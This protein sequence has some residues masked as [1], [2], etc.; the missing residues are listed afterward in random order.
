[1]TI[2][3]PISGMIL[4]YIL[5]FIVFFLSQVNRLQIDKDLIVSTLRMTVQLILVGL[6]L[7]YVFEWES[8]IIVTGIFLLMI[9]FGAW[10][11]ME[12][13]GVAFFQ[14]FISLLGSLFLGTGFVLLFFILFIVGVTPWYDPQFFIP[15]AGMIIGNSMNGSTLAVERFFN[16]VKEKRLEIETKAALGANAKEASLEIF[17]QAYKAS[18]LPTLSSMTGMGIVFLPGM[19]TGQI[20]GGTPPLIAIKYQIT[21]M[22][23]ILASVALSSL[24]ILFLERRFL[25]SSLDLP[26]YNLFKNQSEK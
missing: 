19:M 15:L 8:P 17:K 22:L 12:R 16:G 14:I 26:R 5:F 10:T 9:F 13:S 1:V 21:I 24:M 18:L 6:V 7:V 3:I 20:L 25:F 4:A 2:D 23:A 11:I